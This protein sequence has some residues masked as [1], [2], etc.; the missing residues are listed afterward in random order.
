M[1]GRCGGSR[2]SEFNHSEGGPSEGSEVGPLDRS[3]R[4]M[5]TAGILL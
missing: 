4:K 5:R 1:W 3:G 2:H